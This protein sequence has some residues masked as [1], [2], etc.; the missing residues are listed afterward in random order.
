MAW[1]YKR[2]ESS[3]R[4]IPEGRHRIRINSAEKVVAKTGREMI[5]F[6]FDVSGYSSMLFHNLVFLEDRPEITN[7]MLTQFFDAFPGIP[8]GDFNLSNWVGKVGACQVK[9]EEYN[10]DEVA[11]ISYFIKPEKAESL[12]PWKEPERA[13]KSGGDPAPAVKTD[14]NG[15]IQA[16]SIGDDELPLF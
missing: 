12:P 14:E 8:A 16:G 2:E 11:R 5:A 15:F 6:K 3:F 13:A 9:H 10:G 4:A 1:N 7:R